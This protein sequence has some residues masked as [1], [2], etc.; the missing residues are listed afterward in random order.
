LECAVRRFSLTELNNRS[1]EVV[2]AAYAGPV[3]I[4]RHGKPKFVIM[5]ADQY[6]RLTAEDPRRVFAA[7]ETPKEL[8]TVFDEELDR[9]A[10][11]DG[12]DRGP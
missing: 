5:T 4:T 6:A 1:G 2:E 9:L 12:Y 3:E 10:E 7:G 8:A 11:G